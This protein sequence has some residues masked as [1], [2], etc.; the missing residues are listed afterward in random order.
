MWL[1]M[2]G[3]CRKGGIEPCLPLLG[4]MRGYRLKVR[5]RDDR[6]EVPGRVGGGRPEEAR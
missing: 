3:D 2:G 4:S 6:R 1:V 5:K